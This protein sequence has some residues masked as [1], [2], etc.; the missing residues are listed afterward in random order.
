MFK[1]HDHDTVH[2][3]ALFSSFPQRH[4]IPLKH[5]HVVA[6]Q[7]EFEFKDCHPQMKIIIISIILCD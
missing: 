1:I 6:G 4:Q 2:P 3:A 7:P 5:I